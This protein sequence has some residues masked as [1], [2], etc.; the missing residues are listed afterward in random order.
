MPVVPASQE[1][2][3]GGSQCK[4]HPGKVSETVSKKSWGVGAYTYNPGL[5]RWRKEVLHETPSEKHTVKQMDWGHSST[6]R[7]RP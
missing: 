3:T 1:A 2:E 4:A 7:W 6:G 5:G